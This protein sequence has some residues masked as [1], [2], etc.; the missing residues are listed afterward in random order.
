MSTWLRHRPHSLEKGRKG[1]GPTSRAL[2]A[3]LRSP[4]S[5]LAASFALALA[6]GCRSQALGQ[7][8][9]EPACELEQRFAPWRTWCHTPLHFVG[10]V[11][12]PEASRARLT[13]AATLSVF[14][15]SRFPSD[16]DNGAVWAGKGLSLH[17]A[18]GIGGSLGPLRYG[19]FPA[20]LWAQN[21]DFV[22]AD[23]TVAGYSS[24]AYPWDQTRIDWPQRMG[25]TAT[26]DT[27][28]G[29]SFLE[30][31]GWSRAAIGVSTENIWWGPSKRYPMILGATSDGFPHAYGR[32]PTVAFGPFR[33]TIRAVLGQLSESAYFGQTEWDWR[34][35]ST[36]NLLGA[37]R[38]EIGEGITGVQ[39]AVT[40]VLRQRWGAKPS[41]SNPL[42]I[43]YRTS[44]GLKGE[45]DAD[46]FGAITLVL[47]VTSIGVKLHGTWGRGD[48]FVDAE[49]LL[50]ELEHNQFWAVGLH[51]VWRRTDHGPRWTFSAEHASSAAS[52]TQNTLPRGPRSASVYRHDIVREGHTQRGQ[53]LGA[54]IG[55][56]A[57]ATYVSLKRAQNGRYTGVLV[58]RILWDMDTFR[59]KLVSLSPN[60]QDREWLFG[61]RFGTEVK[62]SGLPNLRLDAFGGASTRWN[63]QYVRFTGSLLDQPE[64]E[65]NLWL[66]LRLAWTP[67][68]GEVRK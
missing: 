38:V 41:L 34:T 11:P 6:S 53:L 5:I 20:V 22:V 46:G 42:R 19:I 35:E 9:G 50:T 33:T 48:F 12:T 7:A 18:F 25:S 63:R 39:V 17:L 67:D 40:S 14:G 23:T 37:L 27:S 30:I 68:R 49:D 10:A 45:Q 58:E 59:R 51:R 3:R 4:A 31:N 13:P 16:R 44:Q 64:R 62:I 24:Y 61:G 56:G 47:P 2:V 36:R 8:S 26:G 1:G 43:F 21:L 55:P 15:R 32:S 60:G 54:S 66:D 28:P 65:T 52:A 29:Q 57:R